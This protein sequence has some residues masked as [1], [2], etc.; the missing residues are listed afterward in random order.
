MSDY[1]E[2][3]DNLKEF[4]DCGSEG[5]TILC[6]LCKDILTIR[7][8]S[9][10]YN[11]KC[12]SC[13]FNKKSPP[14][15]S[16]ELGYKWISEKRGENRKSK[17]IGFPTNKRRR[18]LHLS[19]LSLEEDIKIKHN[20]SKILKKNKQ[21]LPRALQSIL[22]DQGHLPVFFK[23]LEKIIPPSGKSIDEF[24]KLTGLRK[25]L[26][27]KGINN[28]HKFQEEAYQEILN[29][30]NII[31]SAPTGMG[32]TE[33]FLLPIIYSILLAE[34]NPKAREHLGPSALLI[35]PTKALAADQREKIQYY[36][37]G[38]G[39]RVET[40]DGDTPSHKRQLIFQRPPDIL[41]T[42]ADMVHY[43]LMGTMKFQALISSLRF[44]V[45]DEI[46]LCVGSYGTNVLWI[47][48]RLRRF[49]KGLQCIGASATISNAKNFAEI[50]FDRPVKLIST[51]TARKSDM[52]LTILYPKERS[53]LTTIANVTEEF[54]RQD[55][56]TLVF[57]NGHK[58]SEIL[59][60]MLKQRNINSE[61]HRAGLSMSHRKRVEQ[62]FKD[63]EIDAIVSTPT[64]ELGIDI[65]NLDS[66]VS[67]LTNLTSFVQRIGRAGRKG[68][69]SFATLV[70]N[71]DDPI[72][73]Y[74]ARNPDD[75]LTDIQPAY[76][77]PNNELIAYHQVIAML[78]D[79]SLTLEEFVEHETLL[80]DLIR[81]K[82]IVKT[83][84]GVEIIDRRSLYQEMEGF[85]IRGIGNSVRII[86]QQKT[87][88]DRVLPIALKELHEGAIYLH[89]GRTYKV[90]KYDQKT[91]Y[92]NVMQI[93]MNN[94]KTQASRHIFPKILST[95]EEKS[96]DGLAAAYIKL[97]LTEV[98]DGYMKSNIFTN[99]VLGK[100][101][102]DEAISYTFDTM[103]FILSLPKPEDY[104]S[105]LSDKEKEETL[106]GTFHAIEHVLIESGN[107]L[108]GGGST[109]IGGIS[110]ADTG[111]IFIYDGTEGGSGL[112]KLLYDSLDRGIARSLM[113]MEDCPCKRV[114][115]CPRCCY[116][117]SC[118]NNNQPLNRLGGIESLNLFGKYETDLDID[119]TG[120]ETF[121]A[122]PDF[123]EVKLR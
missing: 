19:S 89:G 43:H 6:P 66:V 71:G 94:E 55:S 106:S 118:G 56:K 109:Q 12:N 28:L 85:S 49:T 14:G 107:S 31:V 42:N 41:I 39:I 123:S 73:A 30:E 101:E 82:I 51:G 83:K 15:Y 115:G 90:Q 32:K 18:K 29:G 4:C 108:T 16:K 37:Q 74:Y 116:S 64:L 8:N 103:G 95:Y 78:L 3:C 121:I 34:A 93:P 46:H 25:K 68:Q 70:L 26:K 5:K 1:C 110:L 21:N 54:I 67:Q 91:R 23:K 79:K 10:S 86:H 120:K 112:S 60:L 40:Y 81:R 27:E 84:K 97:Q 119:I 92:A 102:L 113:I 117:F 61:I 38:L 9:R 77:E 62:Q 105:H 57:G 24:I 69:D 80:T 11:F 20:A 99:K 59:N 47:I 7:M 114:D 53:N 72:S 65:G 98:V 45:I 36:C 52:Y 96:I 13:G 17:N 104:V 76:V 22:K 58:A 48:R 63:G 2:S 75:Y 33:S 100:Y 87:L 50:I 111:L 35:Y 44:L 122:R 88:G